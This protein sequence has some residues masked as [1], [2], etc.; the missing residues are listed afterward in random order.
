MRNAKYEHG[1]PV[2]IVLGCDEIGSAVAHAAHCAGYAVVLIDSVD[3]GWARRGMSY[4]DA[5]YVGGATLEHVDACF[6]ASA[7]SVGP[8]LARTDMVAA[9]T[10]SWQGVAHAVMPR[11]VIETRQCATPRARSR[12][13]LLENVLTIGVRSHTVAD[14]PADVVI[15]GTPTESIPDSTT[16]IGARRDP[17]RILVPYTGRFRTRLEITDWVDEGEVVGEVGAFAAIAPASGMLIAL[18]A[19]GARLVAGQLITEIDT[20]GTIGAA[21]GIMPDAR[22]IGL[23]VAGAIRRGAVAPR[24]HAAAAEVDAEPA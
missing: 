24:V 5:W 21:F 2:V 10:W 9:T 11:A 8:V 18:S 17:V 19:R 6:C 16:R 14:W 7:R 22:R 4:V 15:S 12:P 1:R 20:T 3:P 13:P 23:E